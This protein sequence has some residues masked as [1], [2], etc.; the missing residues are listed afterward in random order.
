LGSGMERWHDVSPVL[1]A[2][3]E[4]RPPVGCSIIPMIDLAPIT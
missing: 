4:G 2:G 3:S 1:T